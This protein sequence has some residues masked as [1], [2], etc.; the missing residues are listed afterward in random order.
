MN[1]VEILV[2]VHQE[3]E[4]LGVNSLNGLMHRLRHI[5]YSYPEDKVSPE[6][7]MNSLGDLF[8]K[9]NEKFNRKYGR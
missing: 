3:L 4:T 6:V 8:E 5:I 1:D 9:L 7:P 2:R